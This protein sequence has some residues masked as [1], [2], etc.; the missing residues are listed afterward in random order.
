MSD[1]VS[2]MGADNNWN[3]YYSGKG[4]LNGCGC[5]M[6]DEN[7]CAGEFLCNCDAISGSDSGVITSKNNLPVLRFDF[8]LTA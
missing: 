1:R 3:R 5:S 4:D 6:E 8:Y 2:W 7:E